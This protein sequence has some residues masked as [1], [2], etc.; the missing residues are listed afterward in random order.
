MPRGRDGPGRRAERLDHDDRLLAPIA[1]ADQVAPVVEPQP[2]RHV[3]LDEA[4]ARLVGGGHAALRLSGPVAL[5]AD[6]ATR[7]ALV[8]AVSGRNGIARRVD[9]DLRVLDLPEALDQASATA[10]ASGAG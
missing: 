3:Q 5:L 9:G 10:S 1:F 2:A 4:K 6:V 7:A 8:L